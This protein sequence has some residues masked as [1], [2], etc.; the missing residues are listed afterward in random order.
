VLRA[1]AARLYRVLT[2]FLP[3]PSDFMVPLAPLPERPL[4]PLPDILAFGLW[5]RKEVGK[6][7]G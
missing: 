3:S 4:A 5:R 2:F 7:R 1:P 6:T